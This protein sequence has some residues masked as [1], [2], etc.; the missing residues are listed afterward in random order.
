[1]HKIYINIQMCQPK[2]LLRGLGERDTA[3]KQAVA[4]RQADSLPP[5]WQVF[6]MTLMEC[7]WKDRLTLIW[8]MLRELET[9]G[10]V[11]KSSIYPFMCTVVIASRKFCYDSKCGNLLFI[12]DTQVM[13]Y[14]APLSN[15]ACTAF[16][17]LHFPSYPPEQYSTSLRSHC[18]VY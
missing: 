9:G 13:F 4:L 12:D 1:M 8:T 10:T 7:G 16:C 11:S 17:L 14:M 18:Q 3:V 6:W 15:T 2:L 5:L